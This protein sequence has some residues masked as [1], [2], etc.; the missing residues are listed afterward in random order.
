MINRL[1]SDK[2]T[3]KENQGQVMLRQC[4]FH[5]ALLG[6][7]DPSFSTTL[8]SPQGTKLGDPYVLDMKFLGSAGTPGK[9]ASL[10]QG[11]VARHEKALC[12]R[13]TV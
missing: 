5:V 9:N 6:Q 12:H 2:R 1:F 11:S 4:F 3:L 13:H 8:R 10:N 7:R